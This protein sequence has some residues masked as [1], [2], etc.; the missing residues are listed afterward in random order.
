MRRLSIILLG[1]TLPIVILLSSIEIVS[2]DKQ[3]YKKI[4]IDNNV[5]SITKIEIDELMI[6]TKELLSYLK[7]ANNND[8]LKAYFNDNELL[9]LKDVRQLFRN[10]FVIKDIS[11]LLLILSIIHLIDKSPYNIPFAINN[12]LIITIMIYGVIFILLNLNFSRYFTIFHKLF[13]N[14]ELWLLNPDIDLMINMLPESFFI[15]ISKRI[16]L[17]NILFMSIILLLVNI[18]RKVVGKDGNKY[19]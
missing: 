13:F 10:G 12:S 14:N 11:M 16:I 17:L 2:F 1:I 15:D 9:H 19:N 7:G 3:F 4:Y 5:P 6:I 8:F 18:I